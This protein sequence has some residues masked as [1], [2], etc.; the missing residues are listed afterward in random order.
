MQFVEKSKAETV[1]QH[2]THIGARK[3]L[4]IKIYTDA[5]FNNQ[6]NKIRSTE[7]R[8]MLLGSKNSEKVNSF[9]WKTKKIS[10]VCRSVKGAETRALESGL[11]EAVHYARMVEEIYSGKAN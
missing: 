8:I 4:E 9:S 11:D 2:F 3:D 7:G 1:K 5:S 10:R 6:D